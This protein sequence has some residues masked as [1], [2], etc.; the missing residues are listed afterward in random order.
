MVR[1][2]LLHPLLPTWL[3]QSGIRAFML[4]SSVAQELVMPAIVLFIAGDARHGFHE[5]FNVFLSILVA[6]LEY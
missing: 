1:E 4:F 5:W 2:Q 3:P 6:S